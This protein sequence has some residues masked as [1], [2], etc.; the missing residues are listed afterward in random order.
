MPSPGG[1][2]ADMNKY[3]LV[4][5]ASSKKKQSDYTA[6]AVTPRITGRRRGAN[7]GSISWSIYK[8]SNV[9][10]SFAARSGTIPRHE[11]PAGS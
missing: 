8:D 9:R 6:M 3:R 2:Y 4:D 10:L 1:S 5:P 7:G 11:C